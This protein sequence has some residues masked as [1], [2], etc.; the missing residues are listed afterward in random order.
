ML[1]LRLYKILSD[2]NL[3]LRKLGFMEEDSEGQG[4]ETVKKI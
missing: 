3:R 4:V 2:Q 1:S